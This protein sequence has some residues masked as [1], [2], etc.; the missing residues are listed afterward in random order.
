M[1]K[2][3]RHIALFAILATL[4]AVPAFAQRQRRGSGSEFF[5]AM[6]QALEQSPHKEI[7]D[8]LRNDKV[9]EH[10]QLSEEG[11]EK[12]RELSRSS[13]DKM[14]DL[15]EEFKNT[16][17]SLD[18]MTEKLSA[19]LDD[20]DSQAQ[21]V[22]KDE[23]VD[24]ERLVQL[25]I[26]S[27]SF[28]AIANA[29]VAERLGLTEDDLKSFREKLAEHGERY[30]KSASAEVGNAMRNF[31]PEKM[32]EI[33][34]SVERRVNMKLKT[35]LTEPQQKKFAEMA[36][37]PFPDVPKFGDMFRPGRGGPPGSGPP[38]GRRMGEGGRKPPPPPPEGKCCDCRKENCDECNRSM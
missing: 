21:A 14:R 20:F 13:W 1:S 37:E 36:G 2:P 26:Q 6:R 19:I 38:G 11:S 23:Q 15:S 4:L 34:R 9:K 27:R 10:V 30:R 5:K 28:A 33:F 35:E 25:F 29:A 22:L 32:R 3:V 7:L 8:L 12:L 18:D 24:F 17:P 31:N 16:R